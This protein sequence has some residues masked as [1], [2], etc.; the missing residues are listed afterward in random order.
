M[1]PTETDRLSVIGHFSLEN[2]SIEGL[3][4]TGASVSCLS[5]SLYLRHQQTWGPL[6]PFETVIRGADGDPIPIA[7]RTR[8]LSLEWE[9]AT[10]LAHFVVIIGLKDPPALLGMDVMHPLRVQVDT[11][12]RIAR[13]LRPPCGQPPSACVTILATVTQKIHIP[14]RSVRFISCPTSGTNEDL[15]F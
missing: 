5:H 14:P 12:H 7:G 2:I 10:G 4:D 8:P 9:G 3:V 15:L 6:Q 11:W 1:T 13:P